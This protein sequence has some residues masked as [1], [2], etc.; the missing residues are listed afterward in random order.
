MDFTNV[1]TNDLFNEIKDD[2]SKSKIIKFDIKGR[3]IKYNRY[4]FYLCD[5]ELDKLKD[6]GFTE[7]YKI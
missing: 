3:Y 7:I 5:V 1:L 2:S 4:W 6:Q